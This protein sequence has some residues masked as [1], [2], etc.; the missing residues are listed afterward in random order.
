MKS[1]ADNS[2]GMSRQSER[3][4][5]RLTGIWYLLLAI[6]GMVGFLLLHPRIFVS[7]DPAK[8]LHHIAADEGVFRMRLVLELVIIVS[9]ALAAVWFYRLFRPINA[10]AAWALAAWGMMNAAAI[11][12]SAI[13]MGAALDIATAAGPVDNGRIA[14]IQLLSKLVSHAWGVGG[15]FF[16]LWLLPM[17][18]IVIRSRRMPVWLG[19]IL[20][21]GGAGYLVSAF[22]GYAGVSGAFLNFLTVPATV[23]E[24]WMIA[25]LLIYGIRPATD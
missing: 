13:S 9:Q 19:R 1:I 23:G 7:D 21:L 12:V 2:T 10:W 17:G 8:T 4:T 6:S 20:V 15:L 5:A 16:G 22:L 24:F 3:Q 11:M 14:L 18:Y 25:Y